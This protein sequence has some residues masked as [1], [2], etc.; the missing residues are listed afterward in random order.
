M[1]VLATR[2]FNKDVSKLRD[3]KTAR[4]I[5]AIISRLEKAKTIAEIPN[6]KKLEGAVNAYR[7]RIGDY[8]IGFFIVNDIVELSVFAHRKDIYKVFP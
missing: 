5:E 7:V 2:S 3:G 8:R 4:K 6:V 1:I